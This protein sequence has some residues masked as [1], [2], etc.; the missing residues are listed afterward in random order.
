MFVLVCMFLGHACASEFKENNHHD[1][2]CVEDDRTLSLKTTSSKDPFVVNISSFCHP[3]E[4]LSPSQSYSDPSF[5]DGEQISFKSMLGHQLR[6][7][8][9]PSLPF[10]LVRGTF[11]N[12][13]ESPTTIN[14]VDVVTLPLDLGVSVSD[15][16]ILGTGGLADASHA[17]GSYMWIVVVDPKTRRGVVA[18]WLTS[19][20]GSGVLIPKVIDGRVVITARLEHGHL[21]IP[22]KGAAELETLIVG[23]FEDARLGLEAYADA[24]AKVYQVHLPPQ[25]S[26]YCTWYHAGSSSEKRIIPLAHFV[27]RTLKPY[28]FPSFRSTMVGK[29]AIQRTAPEKTS[30]RTVRMAPSRKA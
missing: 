8:R 28:G 25:P 17:P 22:S 14:A 27:A 3:I 7:S 15:L 20:R 29:R 26:G 1:W 10:T 13:E 23:W 16:K 9:C 24:V 5:G 6:F 21:R 30:P 11:Q 18:G 12:K 2:F 4:S 19:N